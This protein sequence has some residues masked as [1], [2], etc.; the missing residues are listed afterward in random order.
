[1]VWM[2]LGSVGRG[3]VAA[4]CLNLLGLV[5]GIPLCSPMMK[6]KPGRL[7]PMRR[8]GGQDA[9]HLGQVV[10]AVALRG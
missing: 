10:S 2:A 8:P 3:D 4:G 6:K 1:M 5:T 9:D 7:V